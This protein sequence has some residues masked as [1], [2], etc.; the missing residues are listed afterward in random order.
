MKYLAATIE[1]TFGKIIPPKQIADL[2]E[3]SVGI[4]RLLDNI[5]GLFF[6]AAGMAF[7]IMFV[8]GRSR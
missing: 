5:V 4:N 2:G 3:G 1:D 8:W 7:I 6:A